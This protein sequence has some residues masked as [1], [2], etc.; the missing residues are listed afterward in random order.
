[1]A[2]VNFVDSEFLLLRPIL[3]ISGAFIRHL[4]LGVLMC[5]IF[6]SY[7]NSEFINDNSFHLKDKKRNIGTFIS[8]TTN[9][10]A[11]VPTANLSPGLV[12]PNPAGYCNFFYSF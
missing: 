11:R 6:F 3:D 5:G 9:I 2:F 1:M 10:L 8:S 12:I 4:G 7:S